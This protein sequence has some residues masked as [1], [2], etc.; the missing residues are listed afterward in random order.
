MPPSTQSLAVVGDL[1]AVGPA[2]AWADELAAQGGLSEVGRNGLQVCVEE[3]L[4]NLILHGRPSDG[5]KD[6]VLSLTVEAAGAT[7]E[8]ADSCVPFDVTAETP[9]AAPTR[10]D[11]R[12][13]GMGLRLIRAFAGHIAYASEGGRNRLTMRF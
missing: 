4:V 9:P 2:V 13:G 7:V 3:A 12:E 8:I 5:G 1:A 6:I 11:L 10:D